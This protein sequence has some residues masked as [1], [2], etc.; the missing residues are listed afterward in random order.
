MIIEAVIRK[1]YACVYFID[2][3]TGFG[4]TCT[5]IAMTSMIVDDVTSESFPTSTFPT[6]TCYFRVIVQN[7]CLQLTGLRYIALVAICY[8]IKH[9]ITG[10]YACAEVYVILT[11]ID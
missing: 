2:T 10:N 8:H 9:Y 6:S 5:C 7:V 3:A 1:D 4:H 11:R